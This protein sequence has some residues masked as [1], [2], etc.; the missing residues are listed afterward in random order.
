[1]EHR[2][3]LFPLKKRY[4]VNHRVTKVKINTRTK[5]GPV[6]SGKRER[7]R[8]APLLRTPRIAGSRRRELRGACWPRDWRSRRALVSGFRYLLNTVFSPYR[9]IYLIITKYLI[10]SPVSQIPYPSPHLIS[11]QQN[12]SNHLSRTSINAPS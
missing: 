12:P 8:E 10:A 1:M 9:P 2:S 6:R 4:N 3:D 7:Q 11:S 5:G